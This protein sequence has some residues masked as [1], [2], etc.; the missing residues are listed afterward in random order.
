MIEWKLPPEIKIYEALGCLADGRL[1]EEKGE[2]RVYSSSGNKFYI[3]LY[4]AEQNAIMTNDNGT[5]WKGYLGYPAITY[6]MSIGKIQ[7]QEK[8]SV[9]LKDIPWK[10]INTKNKN[11]FEK[12]KEDVHKIIVENGGDLEDFKNEVKSILQQIVDLGMNKLGKR[13]KPPSGY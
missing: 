11:D 3:I 8:H 5:Y 9:A 2:V 1:R 4:D 7:F 10:D 6:L 12:T 13:M